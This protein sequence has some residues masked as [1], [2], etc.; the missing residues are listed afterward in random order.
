MA[1]KVIIMPPA[2]RRLEMYV[3]YTIETL[4]NRSAAKAILSD[5]RD[6]RR[7]LSLI[8]DS[9]QICANPLLAK[10]G[11]RKISFAKHRFLMIYRIQDNTYD[12]LGCFRYSS[13]EHPAFFKGSTFLPA[14]C[15]MFSFTACSSV[16]T[17]GSRRRPGDNGGR[18]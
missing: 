18:G 6:T 13:G 7:R 5:A 16:R 8:A 10:Y 1:Y 15:L 3:S 11:Y 17:A 9:L 4:K 14:G 12:S 2:R